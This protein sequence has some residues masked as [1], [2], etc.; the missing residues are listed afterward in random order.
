MCLNMY[1]NFVPRLII[2]VGL[3]KYSYEQLLYI[4]CNLSTLESKM[5]FG[6]TTVP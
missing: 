6:K 2:G 4:R 1:K 3:I 5:F